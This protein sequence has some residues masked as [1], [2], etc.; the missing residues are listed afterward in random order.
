[1]TNNALS[2]SI[3]VTYHIY[4]LWLSAAVCCIFYNEQLAVTACSM[5]SC[6]NFYC[7]G[8]CFSSFLQSI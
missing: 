7:I 1:M 2:Q 3:L 4:N 5:L 8:A 6:S